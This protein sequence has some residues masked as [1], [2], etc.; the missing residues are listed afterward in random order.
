[1]D[2]PANS[3]FLTDVTGALEWWKL[4]GVDLDY[5]DDPIEWL[6]EPEDAPQ[7]PS[8]WRIARVEAEAQA[9]TEVA[10]ARLEAAQFP[11]DLADFAAWWCREPLLDDG[12]IG[13]RV[14]PSGK[15]GAEAMVIVEAPEPGDRDSLLSGPQGALLDAILTAVGLG[16]E[17]VYLASAL[18]RANPVPDW[19]EA[20]ARQLDAVLRHHIALA[21]PRRLFVLGGNVL[22]LLGHESP[23]RPAVSQVFKHEGA[24]IP[25]LASWGLASLLNQ[26]RAK[27]VLWKAMLD[28]IAA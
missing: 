23:Q 9:Q 14:P 6:R 27:P 26:P 8:E 25:L 10:A 5:L 12:P 1:M 15:A 13:A 20:R 3:D 21:A 19:G 24:S 17:A 16:R 2:Q 22:P 4:A 7:P 11:T 18:P 28:W